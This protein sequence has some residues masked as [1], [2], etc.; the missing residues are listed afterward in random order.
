MK[1]HNSHKESWP[2]YQAAAGESSRSFDHRYLAAKKEIDDRALNHHV[3]QTLRRV[4]GKMDSGSVRILE[5]GAGIGTMLQRF[6]EQNLLTGSVVYAATDSDPAQLKAA[7]HHLSHWAGEKALSLSWSGDHRA[8]LQTD[9][10]D[11][12][13][14]LDCV[15][16]EEPADSADS[17][18][19]HLLIAHAVLDLVDFP[20]V[21]PRLLS[22]L[23][24]N[25]LAYLTCNFDGETLFLPEL[26]GEEEIIDV[27]H[28]SMEARL[29]G[30]SHTGRRLL[31][32]LQRPGLDLLAAGSSDWL[33][34][35]RSHSYSENEIF[36]L[37]TIIATVAGELR[38]KVVSPGN[39]ESWIET[40]HRQVEAGELTLLARHLDFL[41]R[42]VP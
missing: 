2:N 33:I 3:W 24:Q 31:Q 25:G 9:L 20:S 29:P 40:R 13:V 34:H 37:H 39:L 17:A 27:Y 22:R 32:F 8:R 35:P 10:A 14:I 12:T 42:R 11:I 1:E 26:P 19:F 36:F 5:I 38:K 6:V 30:A 41:A 15:R 23:H 21:L 16:A 4:L 28:A 7:R 18:K